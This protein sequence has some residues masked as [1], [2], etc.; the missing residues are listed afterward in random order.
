MAKRYKK[1]KKR[2]FLPYLICIVIILA[3]AYLIYNLF[4]K[5]NDEQGNEKENIQTNIVQEEQQTNVDNN[6][7]DEKSESQ[8]KDNDGNKEV[9]LLNVDVLTPKE[10]E[11]KIRNKFEEIKEAEVVKIHYQLKTLEEGTIKVYYRLED[12]ENYYAEIDI[13]SKEMIDYKKIKDEELMQKTLIENNLEEDVR[14]DFEKY[15]DKLS[16]ETSRL[17]IIIS[18][19]EIIINVSYVS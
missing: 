12:T 8:Q 13:A 10:L 14:Q 15:S 5:K 11:S 3:I 9:I 18:N 17:N 16:D 6:I 7:E 4:I 19:T 2:R 1:N